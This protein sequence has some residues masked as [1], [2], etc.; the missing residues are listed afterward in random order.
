MRRGT[1]PNPQYI[2]VY[3][4]IYVKIYVYVN[5]WI[6]TNI[7]RYVY[8]CIYTYLY[9]S[10]YLWW[11]EEPAP[12]SNPGGGLMTMIMVITILVIC[13]PIKMA[14]WIKIYQRTSVFMYMY[15]Y[16]H[17]SPFNLYLFEVRR[18]TSPNLQSRGRVG[19]YNASMWIRAQSLDVIRE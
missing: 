10:T 12:I 8:K 3:I 4:Y 1:S 7:Y 5:I 18:G 17:V 11:E 14:Q 2:C 16:R 13:T 6:D 9:I 15:E 19:E